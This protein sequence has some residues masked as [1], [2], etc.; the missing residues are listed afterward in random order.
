LGAKD[1][2]DLS[3]QD[4]KKRFGSSL[5]VFMKMQPVTGNFSGERQFCGRS[6]SL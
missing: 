4:E 3:I 5:I 2:P 1:S 6:I